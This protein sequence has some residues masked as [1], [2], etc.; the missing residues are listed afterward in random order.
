MESNSSSAPIKSGL[1]L[2][3]IGIIIMML[4]YVIDISLLTN[5]FF[6]LS[7]MV[8]SVVLLVIFGKK[9]R[10]NE[11]E[12]YLEFGPAFKFVFIASLVSMILS[13]VFQIL[14]Y[15]VIDPELPEILIEGTLQ[16][17]E[18]L[19]ESFG[20]PA[21]DI[22]KALEETEKS[23]EGQFTVKGI[24]SGSYIWLIL[25]VVYALIAGA[26]IKKSRPEFE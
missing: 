23:M 16:N 13:G 20:T 7:M 8:V 19:L 9:Y 15:T 10:D 25:S 17:T 11:L 12:G 22:D 2:G 6:G 21:E 18:E 1:I 26:I 5:L 4:V 3:L 14:L 24:L